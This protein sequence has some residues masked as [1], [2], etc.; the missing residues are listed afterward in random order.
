LSK[1]SIELLDAMTCSA[2][3]GVVNQPSEMVHVWFRTADLSGCD[4]VRFCPS[5]T[6]KRWTPFPVRPTSSVV[7]ARTAD[8]R[9]GDRCLDDRR[10]SL[11]LLPH[12]PAAGQT[13]RD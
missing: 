10:G 6:E 4:P 3:A 7:S 8:G 12:R 11:C 2:L 5:R 13:V 1:R 9:A